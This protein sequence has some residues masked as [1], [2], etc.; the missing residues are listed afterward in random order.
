MDRGN[1]KSQLIYCVVK[2][3]WVGLKMS[4]IKKTYR[5]M[6]GALSAVS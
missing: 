5:F 4:A 2:E 1:S 6:L 3:E